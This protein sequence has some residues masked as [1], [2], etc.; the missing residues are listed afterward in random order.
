MDSDRVH[1]T[2]RE[3]LFIRRTIMLNQ[4]TVMG[5]LVRDPEIRYTQSG[6]PVTSFTLAV[7]RDNFSGADGEKKTDFIDCVAF[8]GTAEF[9]GKYF[10]KGQ[11]AVV[12]GSL[13]IRD[14][15]DRDGNKRR[16]AEILVKNIYFGER[17]QQ[18]AVDVAAEDYTEGFEELD[19]DDGE[20]PF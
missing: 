5:R 7:D 3:E 6:T 10:A 2:I 11:A 13:Q 8:K 16:N 4:I 17:K 9:V 15:T 1:P 14:W 20:F 18:G 12:S 19:E